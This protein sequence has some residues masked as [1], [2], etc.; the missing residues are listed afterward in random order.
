MDLAGL[1]RGQQLR[2]LKVHSR[3]QL[4]FGRGRKSPQ[5]LSEVPGAV[6]ARVS[7]ALR[8][9]G[10]A[11]SA[12]RGLICHLSLATSLRV[13]SSPPQGHGGT[14]PP[15]FCVQLCGSAGGAPGA[16]GAHR[17]AL[18][19]GGRAALDGLCVAHG[20]TERGREGSGG[21]VRG[22]S[23]S[24]TRSG[25]ALAAIRSCRPAP[26][27]AGTA[28]R[29]GGRDTGGADRHRLGPDRLGTVRTEPCQV[30]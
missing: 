26:P 20:R 19:G 30:R 24:R 5:S 15:G 21:S 25:T 7:R 6:P 11:L 29:G 22:S 12:V 17:S 8:P 2:G 13:A 4:G 27:R 16:S 18:T 10:P 9:A 28:N 3:P 14:A 1:L 23:G